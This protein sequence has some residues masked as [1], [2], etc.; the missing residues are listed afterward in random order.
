[1]CCICST[2]NRRVIL[3]LLWP[4]L[5]GME[6]V[7]RVDGGLEVALRPPEPPPPE[8]AEIGRRK[9]TFGRVVLFAFSSAQQFM[10]Q[11][12][13]YILCNHSTKLAR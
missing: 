7:P 6:V 9:D 1:M 11:K 12:L 5:I 13:G 3:I 4:G 10:A 2:I 8:V